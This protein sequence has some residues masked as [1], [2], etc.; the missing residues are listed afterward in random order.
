MNNTKLV[1]ALKGEV[2]NVQQKYHNKVTPGLL[3]FFENNVI[4][5]SGLRPTVQ[6]NHLVKKGMLD[7]RDDTIIM[8]KNK[9]GSKVLELNSGFTKNQLYLSYARKN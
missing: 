7:D 2:T 6:V 8:T 9:D 3:Y 1:H 5:K 4:K